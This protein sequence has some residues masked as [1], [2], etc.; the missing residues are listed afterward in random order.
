LEQSNMSVSKFLRS[1]AAFSAALL[2]KLAC[3]RCK[4]AMKKQRSCHQFLK[5]THYLQQIY[6][7][8]N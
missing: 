2:T 3:C 1:N 6:W 8:H 7:R 4:G 5:M